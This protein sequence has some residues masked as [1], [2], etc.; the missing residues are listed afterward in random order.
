M[1]RKVFGLLAAH[2][3]RPLVSMHHI[4]V[5][6]AHIPQSCE[7]AGSPTPLGPHEAGRRWPL[8]AS[9]SATI[10]AGAGPSPFPGATPSRSYVASCCRV[11]PAQTR[12]TMAIRVGA[13]EEDEAVEL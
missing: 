6:G 5:G 8:S 4:D 11:T 2:P 7:C 1:Y 10:R 9:A 3:V 13:S 12:N